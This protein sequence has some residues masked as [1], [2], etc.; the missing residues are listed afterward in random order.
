[1]DTSCILILYVLEHFLHA[2]KLDPYVVQGLE[3]QAAVLDMANSEVD[4]PPQIVAVVGS[5][6]MSHLVQHQHDV[7][8]TQPHLPRL[9]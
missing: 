5:S 7:S 6:S 1:M 8:A 3:A 9:P 4:H 2:F